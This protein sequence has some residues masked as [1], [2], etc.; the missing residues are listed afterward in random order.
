MYWPSFFLAAK[1][2]LYSFPLFHFR[3]GGGGEKTNPPYS[4]PT[5][6][7]FFWIGR[8]CKNAGSTLA[9]SSRNRSKRSRYQ[10]MSG[11]ARHY[12]R[13]LV[14]PGSQTIILFRNAFSQIAGHLIPTG[15]PLLMQKSILLILVTTWPQN[16][17]THWKFPPSHTQSRTFLT[18]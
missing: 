6:P 12:R 14:W 18:A 10:L 1:P 17:F 4:P 5:S 7:G 15:P 16:V 8:C 9:P 11:C 2:I 13:S 3:R